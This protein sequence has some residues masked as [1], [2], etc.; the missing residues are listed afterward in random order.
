MVDVGGV[1]YH[2]RGVLSINLSE[3]KSLDFRHSGVCSRFVKSLQTEGGL[4]VE[5]K[6]LAD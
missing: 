4:Y 3:Q 5:R 2:I 6:I 1:L